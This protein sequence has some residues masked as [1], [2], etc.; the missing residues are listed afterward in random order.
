MYSIRF[1][2][3]DKREN[4]VVGDLASIVSIANILESTKQK[5]KV[6]DVRGFSL[7]QNDCGCGGFIYWK[8]VGDRLDNLL[9]D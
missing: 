6:S 7:T 4:I 1:L 9:G 8:N 2:E 5:F 3:H